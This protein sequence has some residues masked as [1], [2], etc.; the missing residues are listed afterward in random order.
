MIPLLLLDFRSFSGGAITQ[1][2]LSQ[3]A[4]EYG[5]KFFL[6]LILFTTSAAWSADLDVISAGSRSSGLKIKSSGV[7]TFEVSS[8]AQIPTLK[9]GEERTVKENVNDWIP[10]VKPQ[11]SFSGVKKAIEITTVNIDSK[12]N[13]PENVKSASVFV[14]PQTI[15]KIP[16]IKELAQVAEPSFNESNPTP[17]QIK[18]FT[19]NDFKLIEGLIFLQIHKNYD[20]ALPILSEL[21]NDK[22][23]RQEALFYYAEAARKLGLPKEFRNSLYLV[24]KESKDKEL[25]SDAVKELV[26]NI[27]ILDFYDVKE[28]EPLVLANEVD[29]S[30]NDAYN[31]YRAKHF[32]E[33]GNLGQVEDAVTLI[34][35]KSDYYNDALFIS[36]LFNY[37]QGQIDKA[38]QLLEQVL[39]RTTK[40]NP[41]HTTAA[42]TRARIH[43]QK[44]QFKEAFDTYLE[45]DKSN[46]FWLQ[47]MVEQSWTQVLVKDYEGAAGNMFSLHSDFFKNAYNPESNVVRTV[48]YLNLCQFGDAQSVLQNL[49][50]K[51]GPLYGKLLAYSQAHKNSADYYSSVRAWLKSP[52]QKEVDGLPRS[53]IVEWARHPSYVNIQ[54]NINSYEDEISN[55]NKITL[56][57]IQREKDLLKLQNETNKQL[58]EARIKMND[59]KAN[60][61]ALKDQESSLVKTLSAL[62][63]ESANINRARNQVKVVRELA[64]ARLEKDK[65]GLRSLASDT[66]KKRFNKMVDDLKSLIEQ[67]E[68]LQYEIYAGAG[69][70]IRYQTAGGEVNKDPREQLKVEKNKAMKWSFKGEIWEDEIGHFR[71]SLKSACP[72]EDTK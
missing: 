33:Q 50:R 32:L 36:A 56:N 18:D 2:K 49:G 55:F 16:D 22:N 39:K 54:E 31:F 71:S 66:L 38:A 58:S 59:P 52:Q 5:M 27:K 40:D 26:E 44:N 28:I 15:S 29:I 19:S 10:P 51:Y 63:Y 65:I 70:H 20:M 57:L 4:L 62:K 13:R 47:A 67:N 23:L 48:A 53:F 42:I 8:K 61:E 69:E 7:P 35:E 6:N 64:S 21:F 11:N 12:K 17:K 1:N 60:K 25:K 34:P 30:T 9:I 45:V 41:I 68:V 14:S 46:N 24:A 3:S 72:P 43:F 37:R